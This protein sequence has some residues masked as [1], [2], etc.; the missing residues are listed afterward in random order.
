MNLEY[1]AKS[2][3]IQSAATLLLDK[4][5]WNDAKMFVEAANAEDNLQL[6]KADN[7]RQKHR[8]VKNKLFIVF[9][10]IGETLVDIAIKLAVLY[11]K[12][13]VNKGK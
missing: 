8:N 5:L 11:L 13:Q 3:A 6:S 10:D 7:N 2:L 1:Q 9:G 4:R 12:E